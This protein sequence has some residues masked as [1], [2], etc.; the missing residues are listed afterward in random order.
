MADSAPPGFIMHGARDAMA[1]GLSHIEQQ[2]EGLERAVSENAGLA[3]DLSKTLI[4]SVCRAILEQR[5]VAYSPDDDLPKVFRLT[6][7]SL[8]FLPPEASQDAAARQSLQ[9]TLNGLSTTVHGICELRNHCGF[10]SHGSGGPRTPMEWVQALMTAGAADTIV[11]FLY[12]A[13]M[14]DRVT[15]ASHALRYEENEDFN[16]SVDGL[17]ETVRIFSEEFRPSR[18][19]F[20]LAPEPY[21]LYLAD[22]ASQ[23]DKESEADMD[24]GADTTETQ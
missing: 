16:V 1:L 17:H 14:Q 24:P 12:R 23:E 20:E 3:F 4:E 5:S 18:I 2:V 7:Q 15:P 22:F 19:L 21:R 11:G 9:Q 6:C 8:P 10:A 13:H